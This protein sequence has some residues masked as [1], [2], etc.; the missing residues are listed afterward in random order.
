MDGREIDA[1]RERAR[2]ALTRLPGVLWVGYGLKE[3]GGRLTESLALRVYVAEKRPAADIPEAEMIPDAFEGIPTDVV[4]IAQSNPE[5]AEDRAR[6][7]PLLSGITITNRKVDPAHVARG[8]AVGSIGF[9]STIAGQ[10]GKENVFIV[11]NSHVLA[12]NGGAKGDTL[13]QPAVI[14]SGL[15]PQILGEIGT[16]EDP[17][18]LEHHSFQDAGDAAALDYYVDCGLAKLK[19]SISSWCDCNCGESYR[20]GLFDFTEGV[21]IA[22]T[23]RAS[24]GSS[25]FK[26][27]RA[28]GRTAG[29]VVDCHGAVEVGDPAVLVTNVICVNP[30]APEQFFSGTGD[31][32]GPLVD[33]QNRLVGIHFGSNRDKVEKDIADGINPPR[34][35]VAYSCHIAPVLDFLSARAGGVLTPISTA[36]PPIGP[37]GKARSDAEV[38]LGGGED[39]TV[40]LR[41]RALRTDIGRRVL[42]GFLAHRDE[43][44]ALVN[45]CRP[46][47]SRWHRGKGPAFVA[48]MAESARAPGHSIPREIDGQSR[49]ALL[50]DMADLLARHG[51]DELGAYLAGNRV[52]ALRL[53]DRIDD[54][55]DFVAAAERE[56]VDG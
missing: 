27:G 18:G 12:G 3:V 40:L 5:G 54:L 30:V 50:S 19:I 56:L 21:R 17:G 1:A 53:A 46:I 36:N 2:A 39:Q 35:H 16:I 44:V 15:D 41:E 47:L 9:F 25:V 26:S 37:A 11:S 52:E 55:H 13:Y 14:D 51:S 32:G 31:S 6:H 23:A 49:T 42:G 24:V 45:C 20:H 10:D 29:T 33:A 28:T 34:L 38:M 4:R 43:I 48:H 7:S 8:M 22:G